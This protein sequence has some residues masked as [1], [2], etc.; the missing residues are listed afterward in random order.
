MF[1]LFCFHYLSVLTFG[2]RPY[3]KYGIL[4][5]LGIGLLGS[6]LALAV[7]GLFDMVVWGMMRLAPLTWGLWGLAVAGHLVFE[8]QDE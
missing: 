5:S 7:H 4:S 8:K 2:L 1:Y 3:P 6:Y